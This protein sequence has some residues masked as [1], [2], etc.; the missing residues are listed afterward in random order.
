MMFVLRYKT[1]TTIP[2]YIKGKKII[3]DVGGE[4]LRHTWTTNLDGSTPNTTKDLKR[5]K[6]YNTAAGAK[7][8]WL[9]GQCE[10]VEV[11]ITLA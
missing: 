11:K 6:V 2:S 1:G 9:A 5:A 4:Y 10:V 3:V 8:H 7:C